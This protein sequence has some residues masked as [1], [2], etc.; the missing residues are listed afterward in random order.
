[1]SAGKMVWVDL[2]VDNATEVAAFYT[3]VAGWLTE[4]L[5]NTA[6]RL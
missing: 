3:H 6:G 1:M 4:P 5:I 2:T